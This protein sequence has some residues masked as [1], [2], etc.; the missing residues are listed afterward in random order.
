MPLTPYKKGKDK[1]IDRMVV[2]T[3]IPRCRLVSS[4]AGRGGSKTAGDHASSWSQD[5]SVRGSTPHVPSGSAL[6]SAQPAGLRKSSASLCGESQADASLVQ[7][8]EVLGSACLPATVSLVS[9][10][11]RSTFTLAECI[12]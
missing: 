9:R 10:S 11:V 4:E 8:V 5:S 6:T 3:S 2:S 1:T 7:S 12:F